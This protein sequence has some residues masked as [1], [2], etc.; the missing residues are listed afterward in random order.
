MTKRNHE[1]A[2]VG[3]TLVVWRGRIDMLQTI[4]ILYCANQIQ[5]QHDEAQG[6]L[7]LYVLMLNLIIPIKHG[8]V[9][10]NLFKW[11]KEPDL[12]NAER[13]QGIVRGGIGS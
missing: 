11:L 12:W 2:C 4:K 6:W 3:C 8:K 5:T 9:N 7:E 1:T 10:R 13:K